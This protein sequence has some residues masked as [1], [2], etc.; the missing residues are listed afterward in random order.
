MNLIVDKKIIEIKEC[1]KYRDRLI[2][3]MF[4]KKKIDYCLR[5]KNCNS[6]H[7][8]FCFQKIDVIMTDRNNNILFKYKSL[9]PWHIVLPK[10]NVY[11]VYEFSTDLINMDNLDKIIIK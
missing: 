5:F 1:E 9:K 10:R 7:T 4:K 2:G 6:I 8:F 11:Y 3:I